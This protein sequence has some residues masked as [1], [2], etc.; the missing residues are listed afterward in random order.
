MA[1]RP[2]TAWT[3]KRCLECSVET[4]AVRRT[5][6]GSKARVRSPTP[7]SAAPGTTGTARLAWGVLSTHDSRRALCVSLS[8]LS[9]FLA[10]FGDSR[11]R[12]TGRRACMPRWGEPALPH[13]RASHA[14][15][16]SAGSTLPWPAT[17]RRMAGGL[18]RTLALHAPS[19][20][21]WPPAWLRGLGRGPGLAHRV[22]P[23]R[24]D[25]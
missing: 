19:H 3:R 10:T 1:V 6:G 17:P 2:S 14:C 5:D 20:L 15:P 23:P 11:K 25:G 21:K 8:E 4:Q 7:G 22:G 9:G 16:T 13:A 12:N 18:P 24:S